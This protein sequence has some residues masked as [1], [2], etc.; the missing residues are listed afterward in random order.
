MLKERQ[1]GTEWHYNHPG[2]S[3]TGGVW[4][5]IIRS[6]RKILGNLLQ[7]QT[8]SDETL[9]AIMTEVEAILNARPLTQLS[10]DPKDDE[11]LTPNHLLL[12]RRTP[13]CLLMFS[14]RRTATAEGDGGKPNTLQ[15]S[16]GGDGSKSIC[17]FYSR[18]KNGPS[19]RGTSKSTTWFSRSR[20][21]CSTWT[22]A[23]G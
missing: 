2:A 12:L 10:M 19:L 5:R 11:P 9:I 14:V 16:F 3:H 23:S 6:V 20:R 17:P 4:E 7:Q 15:I 22:L 1:R 18:G 21:Q 13:V 8:V